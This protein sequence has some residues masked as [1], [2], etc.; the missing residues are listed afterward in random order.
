MG[1]SE[2][3]MAT[4]NQNSVFYDPSDW[5]MRRTTDTCWDRK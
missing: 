1:I 3:Y 4:K 5:G 2:K